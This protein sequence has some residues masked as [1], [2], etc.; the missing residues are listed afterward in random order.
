MDVSCLMKTGPRAYNLYKQFLVG[1]HIHVFI[2]H[3]FKI[4]LILFL[5][6]MKARKLKLGINIDNGWMYR[7]YRNRG[8]GPIFLGVMFLS[9][10]SHS[11]IYLS[12]M[13][14]SRNTFPGNYESQKAET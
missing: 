3:Q 1:F 4:F 10:F 7:A 14:H 8:Q 5:G 2:Y 12:S 9:R 13:K 6:A 11:C